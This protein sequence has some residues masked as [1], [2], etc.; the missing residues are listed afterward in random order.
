MSH[1]KRFFAACLSIRGQTNGWRRS[2]SGLTQINASSRVLST[3]ACQ[4]ARGAYDET[5]NCCHGALSLLPAPRE[6]CRR[7]RC[8]FVSRPLW[9][10]SLLSSQPR[11]C[12]RLHL[13]Q[14]TL[15]PECW[16][17]SIRLD[18]AQCSALMSPARQLAA[19]HR[20]IRDRV[21]VIDRFDP[22][23][24]TKLNNLSREER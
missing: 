10:M 17:R 12:S 9:P 2:K 7:M 22:R 5:W 15:S 8:R 24:V 23:A 1:T 6:R 21:R 4:V 18:V 20:R 16:K 14:W 11:L 3:S 19:D 13:A